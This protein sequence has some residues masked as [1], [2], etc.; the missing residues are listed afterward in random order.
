[1]R[2]RKKR[3]IEKEITKFRIKY[4]GGCGGCKISKLNWYPCRIRSWGRSGGSFSTRKFVPAAP[5]PYLKSEINVKFEQDMVD[6]FP[7]FL[8]NTCTFYFYELGAH[9][10]LAPF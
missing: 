10:I 4:I 3:N 1:M 9:I 8:I 2:V 5:A 7:L 6:I